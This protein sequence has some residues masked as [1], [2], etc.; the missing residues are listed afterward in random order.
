MAKSLPKA[1]LPIVGVPLLV[2]TLRSMERSSSV[3][4]GILIVT[5]GWKEYCY[6]L[7]DQYGPFRLSWVVIHGGK[8]RQDSVHLGLTQLDKDC[9]LVIIHDG[10][11][12]FVT[13]GMID[14][15]LEMAAKVGGAVVAIPAK[16]TIKRVSATGVIA[17]TLSRQELWLAQTPQTFCVPL[18]RK[19]HAWALA[20]NVLTTDDAALVEK[21][22]GVVKVIPGN[23]YNIKITTPEDLAL[24]EMIIQSYPELC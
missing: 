10:A 22:G 11:R 4:K 21:I 16:D 2:R 6:G 19:A 17:E 12:P 14:R 15:S 9:E 1:F 5:P 7:L 23:P 3:S 24:A 20:N 8:E 18:I 13:A